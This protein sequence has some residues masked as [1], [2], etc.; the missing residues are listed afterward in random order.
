MNEKKKQGVKCI[1]PL[2]VVYCK[3]DNEEEVTDPPIV[4]KS[5]VFVCLSGSDINKKLSDTCEG[6]KER[7]GGFV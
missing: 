1:L 7:I 4:I 2:I 5:K 3:A 6:I